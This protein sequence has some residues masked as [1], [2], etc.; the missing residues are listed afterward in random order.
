MHTDHIVCKFTQINNIR[1]A[2]TGDPALKL[3]NGEITS[4]IQKHEQNLWNEYLYVHWDHMHNTH[5]LWNTIHGILCY[6]T[7]HKHCQTHNTKD[8]QTH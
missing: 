1:R 8:K 3:L 6:Q 2:N 7:I 4:D 5:I